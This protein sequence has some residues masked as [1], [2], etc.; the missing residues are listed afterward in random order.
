MSAVA[1]ITS[2]SQLGAGVGPSGGYKK[3]K[4]PFGSKLNLFNYYLFQISS[5]SQI[6]IAS[7]FGSLFLPN[8]STKEGLIR[9]TPRAGEKKC[10]P[11]KRQVNYKRPPRGLS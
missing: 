9:S 3:V 11:G 8:G 10:S 6:P 1:E 4:Q 5:Y 7:L 2:I